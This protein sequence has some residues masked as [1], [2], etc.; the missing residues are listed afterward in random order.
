MVLFAVRRSDLDCA[1]FAHFEKGSLNGTV[2]VVSLACNLGGVSRIV[3]KQVMQDLACMC[4]LVISGS[5]APSHSFAR[6]F[7]PLLM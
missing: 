7:G 6:L 3:S 1:R 4:S 2:E 5:G